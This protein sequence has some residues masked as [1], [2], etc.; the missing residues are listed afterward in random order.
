MGQ[1]EQTS[2]LEANEYVCLC[3]WQWLRSVNRGISSHLQSQSTSCRHNW[4]KPVTIFW[5]VYASQWCEVCVICHWAFVASVAKATTALHLQLCTPFS[6]WYG[7]L[8]SFPGLSKPYFYDGFFLVV[9][10][11][12]VPSMSAATEREAGEVMCRMH[13]R[14]S[15][16]LICSVHAFGGAI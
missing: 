8:P 3:L 2:F 9:S 13:G 5:A 7:M 15:D 6:L 4:I 12:A 1:S 11:S 10:I 16:F 14:S